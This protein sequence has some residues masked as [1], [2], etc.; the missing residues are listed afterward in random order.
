MQ[1]ICLTFQSIIRWQLH[2]C[3]R[4]SKLKTN[5]P[6]EQIKSTQLKEHQL[7]LLQCQFFLLQLLSLEIE[8]IWM[9]PLNQLVSTLDIEIIQLFS[10]KMI[11][12]LATL[13][14]AATILWILHHFEAIQRMTMRT[15]PNQPGRRKRQFNNDLKRM[16]AAFVFL[17][18]LVES[19]PGKYLDYMFVYFNPNLS[20]LPLHTELL[21]VITSSTK[22]V[23]TS[24]SSKIPIVLT[25]VNPPT[26]AW[27]IDYGLLI[28][29]LAWD[30]L[31]DTCL[32]SACVLIMFLFTFGWVAFLW[33]FGCSFFYNLI[34]FRFDSLFQRICYETT[35]YF[36]KTT[37]TWDSK[38]FLFEMI[39]SFFTYDFT[40]LCWY[41]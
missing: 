6:L 23:S 36:L 11:L 24:G 20:S 15:H 13:T 29:S 34:F 12:L 22:F 8:P 27:T 25:V 28:L 7:L 30:H 31:F 9:L 1:T 18:S 38:T 39:W 5:W 2:Q 33:F 32:C 40:C 35:F 3:I 14:A 4:I 37:Y 21:I 26:L 16:C 41:Q 19:T 10:K 17:I